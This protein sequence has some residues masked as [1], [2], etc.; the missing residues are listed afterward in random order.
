MQEKSYLFIIVDDEFS[1]IVIDVDISHFESV[2]KLSK[3]KF[4]MYL[5]KT[6]DGLLDT[7]TPKPFGFNMRGKTVLSYMVERLRLS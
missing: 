1:F 3:E 4:R 7:P 2:D 6:G 5:E